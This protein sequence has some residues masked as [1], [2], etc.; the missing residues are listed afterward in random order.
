MREPI[1]S[2]LE[3]VSG[4]LFDFG[5]IDIQPSIGL[6]VGVALGGSGITFGNAGSAAE[7]RD[8][9]VFQRSPGQGRHT[10]ARPRTCRAIHVIVVVI[11]GARFFQG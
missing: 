11:R 2:E 9:R 8:F 5:N 10:A 3:A 7:P 4:G 1:D 6:Q